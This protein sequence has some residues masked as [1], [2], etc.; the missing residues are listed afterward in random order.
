MAKPAQTTDDRQ[1]TIYGADAV[2]RFAVDARQALQR[3]ADA[4]LIA[5]KPQQG[6]DGLGLFDP[7]ARDTTGTPRSAA[8]KAGFQSKGCWAMARI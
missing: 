3:K 1:L 6:I 7:H 5:R 8:R 2:R 4:R